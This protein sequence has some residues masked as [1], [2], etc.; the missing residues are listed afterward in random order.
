[1]EIRQFEL[2]VVFDRPC[3][4]RIAGNIGINAPDQDR[5]HRVGLRAE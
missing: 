4:H 1:M 3:D 5:L 2:R